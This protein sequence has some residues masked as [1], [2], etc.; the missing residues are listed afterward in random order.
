MQKCICGLR[1]KPELNSEIKIR[2]S[3]FSQNSDLTVYV[4]VLP[5]GVVY[6]IHEEE[7]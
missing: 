4:N 3:L 2:I 6:T 1:L 5:V 7:D